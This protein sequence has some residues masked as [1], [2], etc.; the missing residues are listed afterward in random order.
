MKAD[1][2]NV[3]E[4]GERTERLI[5]RLLDGEITADQRVELDGIL[6]RDAEARSLLKEYGEI[7]ARAAE[8]LRHDLCRAAT[9]VALRRRSGLWLATAG[10]LVA[11]AAVIAFSFLPDLWTGRAGVISEAGGQSDRSALGRNGF[12]SSATP[13]FRGL[14]SDGV[15]KAPPQFVDY[16][17]SDDRPARRSRDL[18]RD[19]IGI[20]TADPNTIVV[21][22]RDHR[23]TRITPISGDF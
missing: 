23:T 21:I 1:G 16:G 10:G 20:P 13:L 2:D 18:R 22:Q 5:C 15:G 19:W 4:D 3:F 7:D 8:A 14:R 11:A 9:A 6:A 12:E 17:Y